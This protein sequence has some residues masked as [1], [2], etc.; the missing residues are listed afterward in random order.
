M[1]TYSEFINQ[2][3]DLDESKIKIAKLALKGI[4]KKVGKFLGKKPPRSIDPYFANKAVERGTM[5]RGF[6]GQSAKNIAKYKKTGVTPTV[7]G[8]K[9][10]PLVQYKNNPATLDWI[11]RT[12]YKGTARSQN[13][14]RS[15]VDAYFATAT[16]EGRKRA[17]QY[18][19]RGANYE[20]K[21]LKNI[22]NPR[23]DKGEVMDV[24][25]NKKSVRKGWKGTDG[26][27][28]NPGDATERIA[29]AKDIIPVVPG[30]SAKI[31]KYRL[32]KLKRTKH[33]RLNK[34]KI[35]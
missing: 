25:V 28:D 8:L 12:G 29:K 18:A 2:T 19:K 35:K 9:T 16:K 13:M 32:N 4:S 1:K 31:A 30:P 15:G 17:G 27:Y 26:K 14:A 20:N 24:V 10:D 7:S 21:K 23:K 3:K 34:D 22:F 11:K 6:H 5:V 33:Q